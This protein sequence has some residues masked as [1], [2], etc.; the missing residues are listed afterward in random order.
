MPFNILALSAAGPQSLFA[1]FVEWFENEDVLPTSLRFSLP[2]P[3]I[4]FLPHWTFAIR[5]DRIAT[6]VM[7]SGL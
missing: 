6:S 2:Y 7:S 5:A 4:S 1:I 3:Q